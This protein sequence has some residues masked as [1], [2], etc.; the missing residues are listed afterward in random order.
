MITLRNRRTRST[1]LVFGANSERKDSDQ[2]EEDH[3]V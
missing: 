1:C 3:P 2:T